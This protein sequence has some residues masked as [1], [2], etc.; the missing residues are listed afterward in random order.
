[1]ATVKIY[2]LPVKSLE[3]AERIFLEEA[4]PILMDQYFTKRLKKDK[5]RF[6]KFMGYL[7]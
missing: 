5:V 3:K 2:K 6:L 7:E 1:M 4:T